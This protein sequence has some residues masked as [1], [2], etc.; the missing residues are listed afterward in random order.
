MRNWAQ[1]AIANWKEFQPKRYAELKRTGKLQQEA[2]AAANLTQKEMQELMDHGATYPEAWEQVRERYLF[3]PEERGTDEKLPTTAAYEVVRMLTEFNLSLA[4]GDLEDY[5]H[6]LVITR[7]KNKAGYDF[8]MR[9]REPSIIPR[10][11]FEKRF[12]PGG[13][14]KEFFPA[15]SILSHPRSRKLSARTRLG[16]VLDTSCTTHL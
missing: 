8:C 14:R 6:P 10:H 12:L 2:E 1:Q 16:L 4:E 5:Q 3:P 7:Q 15:S 11:F 13:S 9:G